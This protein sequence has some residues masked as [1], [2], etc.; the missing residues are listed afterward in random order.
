MAEQ[1]NRPHR[2]SGAH[3]SS[4]TSGGDGPA[5]TPASSSRSA[6][7]GGS[8]TSP[9]PLSAGAARGS[10]ARF[11]SGGSRR[12]ASSASLDD[13]AAD[14]SEDAPRPI[15]VDPAATGSFQKLSAGQG[16]VIPTRDNADVAADAARQGLGSKTTS[17]RLRVSRP[18]VS[19][20]PQKL[21]M[22]RNLFIGLGVAA[23][24]IIIALA[25]IFGNALR[26][27]SSVTVD[28]GE[29]QQT[30][31][32][33]DGT[34]SYAGYSYSVAQQADGKYAVM[35]TAQGSSTPVVLFGLNGTP[36]SLVLC[37]GVICVPEN[38]DGTWD[39][40]VYMVGDGSVATQ[41]ADASGN[42][43]GGDGTLTSAALEGTNISLIDDQG[44]ETSAPLS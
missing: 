34:I 1:T 28:T 18:Q 5:A 35:R 32:T 12:V 33:I 27:T 42:P 23:A 10:S 7:S 16:A 39:V 21:Q 11:S 6:R 40:I 26:S 3:F 15:G 41:L 31:V 38:L 19:R 36:V 37:N 2:R 4:P 43:V 25:L 13:F 44:K 22:N 30:Q 9:R 8:A 17:K 24:V 29:A 14:S 20:A